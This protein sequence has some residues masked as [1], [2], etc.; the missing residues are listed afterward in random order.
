MNLLGTFPFQAITMM[1]VSTWKGWRWSFFA[2]TSL[3]YGSKVCFSQY[4]LVPKILARQDMGLHILLLAGK[5]GAGANR[6]AALPMLVPYLVKLKENISSQIMVLTFFKIKSSKHDWDSCENTSSS[7]GW[8][9]W[10]NIHMEKHA[11]RKLHKVVAQW[12]RALTAL[13]NILSSNPSNHMVA[14]NHL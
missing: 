14:H 12:L 5:Y 1:M 2:Y 3:V 9:Q 7:P 10:G 11:Y 13:S 6:G 4:I 8:Q